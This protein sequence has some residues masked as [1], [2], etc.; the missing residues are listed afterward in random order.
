MYRL[1]SVTAASESTVPRLFGWLWGDL[2]YIEGQNPPRS[3]ATAESEEIVHE[4]SGQKERASH[5]FRMMRIRFS[6]SSI[7][8]FGKASISCRKDSLATAITWPRRRSP[9]RAM[10]PWPCLMRSRRIPGFSTSRVVV[11]TT[12]VEGYPA[13]YTRS[14]WSTSAGR[15]FPGFVL[16][17]RLISITYRWPRLI[18][19]Y[20]LRLLRA[21]AAGKSSCSLPGRRRRHTGSRNPGSRVAIS[22]PGFFSPA[23]L[24]QS[25][26]PP[27]C[28]R[29][30]VPCEA[31]RSAPLPFLRPL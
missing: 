17:R 10:P 25:E 26:L 8:E 18:G 7:K 28:S 11:G 27:I 1:S 20:S 15:S 4:L 9:S 2:G 14:D 6:R 3:T 31:F 24:E 22:L 19:I 30:P 16:M 12:I 23:L 13:S 29:C 5:R 21:T